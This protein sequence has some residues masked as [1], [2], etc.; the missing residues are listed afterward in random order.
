[1]LRTRRKKKLF[2]EARD[3]HSTVSSSI[4]STMLLRAGDYVSVKLLSRSDLRWSID[5]RTSFSVIY[6]NSFMKSSGFLAQQPSTSFLLNSDSSATLNKWSTR[7]AFAN[8]HYSG[9]KGPT[10]K[11]ERK[12]VIQETGFHVISFQVSVHQFEKKEF[13]LSLHR[14]SMGHIPEETHNC[15]TTSNP[16]YTSQLA[17]TL[18]LHS[19]RG[20]EYEVRVWS[21]GGVLYTDFRAPEEDSHSLSYLSA[22]LLPKPSTYSVANVQLKVSYV[23]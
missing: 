10:L 21:P 19:T 20:S 13:V 12:I 14:F 3:R 18:L 6:L 16:Y 23:F 5:K 8:V 2:I 22:T 4:T 11:N 17:C 7:T 15:S 1:M 9:S